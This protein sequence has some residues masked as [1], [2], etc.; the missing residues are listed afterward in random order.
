MTIPSTNLPLNKPS[1][2]RLAFSTAAD[3]PR[4][5]AL[6]APEV[7]DVIDPDRHV[8]QRL[9]SSFNDAVVTGRAA[10]LLDDVNAVRALTMAFPCRAIKEGVKGDDFLNFGTSLSQV[11]GYK[12]SAIVISAL[13]LSEWL[14]RPPQGEIFAGIVPDN[15]A[16]LKVY[17]D[18]LK[19]QECRDS[20]KIKLI[21][22]P[23]WSI[24]PDASDPTGATPRVM[25]MPEDL[26]DVGWF[27]C[28][29]ETLITQAQYL[30]QI[31][32][33]GGSLNT[34]NAM[35]KI[36]I[37]LDVLQTAGLTKLR[38]KAIAS[39]MISRQSVLAM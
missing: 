15:T 11:P 30:L 21:L 24:L 22:P 28:E 7:K 32:E 37:D 14:Q 12:L 17:K 13:A 29:K 31:M 36:E 4:I 16:S 10:M 25:G 6:M 27:L 26:A 8:A 38:L 5:Q 1:R 23:A 9:L 18:L 39:G 2:L 20:E 3:L 19:W 33:K 34:K 35:D